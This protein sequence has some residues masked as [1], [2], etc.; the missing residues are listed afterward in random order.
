MLCPIM[1]LKFWITPSKGRT[2]HSIINTATEIW[3][4]ACPVRPPYT[5]PNLNFIAAPY[6]SPKSHFWHTLQN[7][8]LPYTLVGTFFSDNLHR[9]HFSGTSPRDGSSRTP[10][11]KPHHQGKEPMSIQH[12]VPS[13]F[14]NNAAGILDYPF[15]RAD[16]AFNYQHR[17]RNLTFCMPRI[18]PQNCVSEYSTL[19]SGDLLH[20]PNRKKHR[21]KSWAWTFP[22]AIGTALEYFPLVFRMRKYVLA[23]PF[24]I[25]Y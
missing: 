13:W 22:S 14:R 5:T 25:D 7:A 12:S 24:T 16:E 10:E 4:F 3:L 21:L 6:V 20:R 15:Q 18:P 23:N 17:D 2:R 11:G 8:Q 1:R 9:M 19:R